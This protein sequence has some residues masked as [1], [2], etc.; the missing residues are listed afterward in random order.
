MINKEQTHKIRHS[1]AHI[2]A[3][4]VL[5]KYPETKVT[6][7]PV[8]DNGFYYDF[9]FG[10]IKISDKDLKDF[11]KK[12]KKL[13]SQKLNFEKT[14]ISKENA[15][16]KFKDNEYKT[17]LINEISENGETITL[18]KT[19]DFEDLCEGPHVK[20][21]SEID[22]SAFK[23]TKISGAYWRGDEKNKMLTRIYGV[24]FENKEDFDKYNNAVQELEKNDHRK[25]GKEL[26]LFTF[27]DHVGSG[28]PLY[29]PNGTAL[30]D[31]LQNRVENI[32][33]DYG[34]EKVMTP[35]L[36][37]IELF[38]ISGHAGKYS[39]ELF[40]VTSEKGHDFALKPVQCP[41]QTQ[42]YA[43]KPRSYKELP[44]RYMES[45]KQYRAEQSGEVGGL[46]RVYA[47]TVEDGHSFCTPEQIKDE[48]KGMINII[49][50][51]YE[52][53]GLWEKFWVSLSVRDPETPE[54]YIGSVE[55]WEIAEKMLEEVCQEMDLK[56][57]RMEGEAA[58][59]GPKVDFQFKDLLGRE[60][61]IPTVQLD[62][63]TPE[64][65]KLEY[66]DNNGDKKTP[67]MIH[68]AILG[69]YERLIV[70]LIEQL[71]N[72]FP[73]FWMAP[74]QVEIIPVG[75]FA[76]EYAK[77]IFEEI[78]KSGIRV[79]INNSDDGFG[80]KI[81]SA[82]KMRIP[83]FIVIGEKD[84][85][86]SKVTLENRDSGESVQITLKEA[87]EIFKKENK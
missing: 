82:K 48:V 72:R 86:E 68:R 57:V 83:Y 77:N 81:R 26:D 38:E 23:L 78:K 17:E 45:N 59:Y 42:I 52:P 22:T 31:A 12:M 55:N 76:D 43:A 18:Y 61:Q 36:A 6:I 5:D 29:T 11:S 51:F 53:L 65:F 54:K 69:S 64:R 75:D 3:I 4:A 49:K 32:C 79:K 13:I 41:H 44:I 15:L 87:L 70:L 8:V 40:R 34:F 33:R 47:I 14:E 9:D 2:L 80:K 19:G 56:A 60:I 16:E 63:A 35:H 37:K 1:L 20:N 74:T 50:E 7:G 24:A 21:T 28:L 25:V 30:I 10:D 27:S 66:I 39:E 71:G 58:I 73:L 67:V 62:F 46:R 84:I 85:E